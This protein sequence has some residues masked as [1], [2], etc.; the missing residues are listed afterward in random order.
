MVVK[1]KNEMKRFHCA[2]VVMETHQAWLIFKMA[3]NTNIKLEE[4][5]L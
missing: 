3:E 4:T 2:T 5:H 1:M